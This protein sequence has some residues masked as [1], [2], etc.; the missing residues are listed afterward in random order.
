MR[1]NL[2]IAVMLLMLCMMLCGCAAL[3]PIDGVQLRNDLAAYYEKQSYRLN[4][5]EESLILPYAPQVIEQTIDSRKDTAYIKCLARAVSEYQLFAR[6]DLWELWYTYDRESETWKLT[7][8]DYSQ[9]AYELLSDLTKD[10][11]E[12]LLIPTDGQEHN[13]ISLTTERVTQTA[14]AVYT[15]QTTAQYGEFGSVTMNAVVDASFTWQPDGG[16]RYVGSALSDKTTYA[17][18]LGCYIGSDA[19]DETGCS[20]GFD[21]IVIGDMVC[22]ENLR[23][24]GG[25][26]AP[27]KLHIGNARLVNGGKDAPA[28][29]VFSYMRDLREVEDAGNEAVFG[30]GSITIALCEDGGYYAELF[31]G[32]FITDGNGDN[33]D[34]CCAGIAFAPVKGVEE[35][36]IEEPVPE[37]QPEP[38]PDPIPD[39]EP[40]PEPTPE[41]EPEEPE[42]NWI[43]SWVCHISGILGGDLDLEAELREDG[44]CLV[45]GRM[46]FGT[47]SRETTYYVEDDVSVL[48]TDL[49]MSIMLGRT[50]T[51]AVVYDKQRDVLYVCLEAGRY[52]YLSRAESGETGGEY[53]P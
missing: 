39:P 28:V 38:E 49:M 41:P 8:K 13:L 11:Y 24:N 29:I 6:E 20:V 31:F 47:L 19:A 16:W 51:V 1:R 5:G 4:D 18:E 34:L 15:Y 36:K 53:E 42:R 43:G 9:T 52:V 23:Y 3:E 35:V 44:T 14:A 10:N 48:P 12:R 2:S 22:I 50:P 37:P 27:G 26:Y 45:S 40:E 21:L 46:K 17:G 25:D 30:E 7:D 32:G 33:A